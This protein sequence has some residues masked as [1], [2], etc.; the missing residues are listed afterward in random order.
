MAVL[1]DL[2]QLVG[3]ENVTNIKA[4]ILDILDNRI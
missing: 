1:D 4:A 3:D 2:K